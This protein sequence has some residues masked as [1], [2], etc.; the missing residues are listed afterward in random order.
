MNLDDLSLQDSVRFQELE[1]AVQSVHR[2]V[3]G[4]TCRTCS[5][6][7]FCVRNLDDLSLQDSVRSHELEIAVQSVHRAGDCSTFR[8]VYVFRRTRFPCH[9]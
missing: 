4:A 9:P 7:F 2:A 5:E 3:L 8:D 1:I 6:K